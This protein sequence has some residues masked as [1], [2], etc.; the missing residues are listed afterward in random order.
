MC[1]IYNHQLTNGSRAGK[2]PC[3]DSVSKHNIHIYVSPSRLRGA[4]AAGRQSVVGHRA[5]SSVG[6]AAVRGTAGRPRAA[7][8]SVW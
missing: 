2:A 3:F 4:P 5:R 1:N 6:E 8:A 7:S